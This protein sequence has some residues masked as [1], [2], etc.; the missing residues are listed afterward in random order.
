MFF[1]ITVFTLPQCPSPYRDLTYRN[2]H[3]LTVTTLRQC[4]S[5]YRGYLTETS[6][7]LLWLPYHNNRHLTVTTLPHCSL[8]YR[9]Y[10]TAMSATLPQCYITLLWMF[11]WN[12][13]Y[14]FSCCDST[15]VILPMYYY[16][17][18]TYSTV[19]LITLPPFSA[20]Y[21]TVAFSFFL[22]YYISCLTKN[23]PYITVVFSML[24]LC[25]RNSFYLAAA[26]PT[27]PEPYFFFHFFCLDIMDE[28]QK[29]S[30]Q[31]FSPVARPLETIPVAL[32]PP[33]ELRRDR[34]LVLMLLVIDGFFRPFN[35]D[36]GKG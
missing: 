9:V 28:R 20:S 17:K 15:V 13:S 18:F 16:E 3:H 26:F 5:S 29:P 27:K 14:H 24:S 30:L 11:Y 2:V 36:Y 1:R 32:E 23:T 25:C 10:L 4:P 7:T 8:S 19:V 33:P 6:V 31:L 34:P 21:T 35:D 12:T 22:Y